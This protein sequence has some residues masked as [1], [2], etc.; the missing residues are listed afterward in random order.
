MKTIKAVSV[1]NENF[2]P[3]GYIA[4]IADPS[5]SYSIGECPSVF[6]RDM[7]LAPN[8]DSAPMAFGSLKID[9]HPYIIKDVEYHTY[10]CEVMM[11]LDDDMIIYVGPA[12]N[13]ALELDKLKAFLIPK[14]T[15]I[16]LRA[17]T[18]HGAPYPTHNKNG[19]VLICLPER[20]YLNDT[21]KYFLEDK[22]F[23]EIIL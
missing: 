8:A 1:T 15:L 4:N 7:V 10:T 20:S 19:T 18:W 5:D 13:D 11:P 9:M 21:K 2:H 23:V 22:D 14:D 6:Y 17:G 16:V 3:Y 12:S